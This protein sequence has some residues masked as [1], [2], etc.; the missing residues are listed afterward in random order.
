MNT[1]SGFI[2]QIFDGC[3]NNIK[4]SISI[5]YNKMQFDLF[6]KTIPS[7]DLLHQIHFKFSDN[8]ISENVIDKLLIIDIL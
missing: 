2:E 1:C 5:P 6:L 4:E 7:V 3:Y 8:K